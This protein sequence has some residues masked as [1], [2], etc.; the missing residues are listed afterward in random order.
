MNFRIGKKILYQ[1]PTSQLGFCV[2][3]FAINK[4]NKIFQIVSVFIFIEKSV[5]LRI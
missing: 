5:E 1:C 3:H 4:A 2:K